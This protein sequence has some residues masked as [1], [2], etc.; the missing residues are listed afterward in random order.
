[1]KAIDA[2]KLMETIEARGTKSIA[3]T[4]LSRLID[5][6]PEVGAEPTEGACAN[7]V[8]FTDAGGCAYFGQQLAK[9]EA[10]RCVQYSRRL[11]K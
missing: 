11:G 7:C 3:I 5:E 2:E 4:V 1:M 9:P 6:A 8:W 10:T